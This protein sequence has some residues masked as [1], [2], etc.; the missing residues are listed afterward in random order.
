MPDW[1]QYATDK[2][3]E[4]LHDAEAADADTTRQYMMEADAGPEDDMDP[5]ADYESFRPNR[6]KDDKE[7]A[8]SPQEEEFYNALYE[9]Y[10]S[11]KNE[12]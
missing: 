9:E 4:G 5:F 1:K 8:L 11:M 12:A 10:T 2:W 3:K 6:K 7:S